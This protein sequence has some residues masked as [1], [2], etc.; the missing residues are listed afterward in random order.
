MTEMEVAA[1]EEDQS[2]ALGFE[3]PLA[4]MVY[5]EETNRWV[6]NPYYEGPVSRYVRH[7]LGSVSDKGA[8]DFD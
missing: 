5:I 1:Y 6:G 4:P 3:D 8:D 2:Y 7:V